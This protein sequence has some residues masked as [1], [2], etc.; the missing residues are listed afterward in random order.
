MAEEPGRGGLPDVGR[1][2]GLYLDED[3]GID[4]SG[5]L[6]RDLRA[7]ADEFSHLPVVD[8]NRLTVVWLAR[9]LLA[10]SAND[11]AA[12]VLALYVMTPFGEGEQQ[13]MGPEIVTLCREAFAAIDDAAL[14]TPCPHD[15]S[16]HPGEP[17]F[18]R[19]PSVI[20]AVAY[21][22]DGWDE[23]DDWLE[24]RAFAEEDGEDM[25]EYD[26][27]NPRPTVAGWDCPKHLAELAAN[28]LRRL[29]PRA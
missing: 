16:G 8:D 20:E 12:L 2:D 3:G 21:G 4:F 15:E 24:D 28:A 19:W 13:W 1:L 22:E 5:A 7:R 29:A 9:R 25:E 17:S 26:L 10:G 11:D 27:D 23:L 14:N 6:K 18:E